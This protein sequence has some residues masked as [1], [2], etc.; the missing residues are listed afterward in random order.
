MKNLL[1]LFAILGEISVIVEA[2]KK[3][4]TKYKEIA[5]KK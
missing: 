2:T 1:K 4:V 3:V 5:R